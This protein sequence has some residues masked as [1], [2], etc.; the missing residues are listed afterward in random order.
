MNVSIS[1]IN[2]T[3]K[4]LTVEISPDEIKQEEQAL[5]SEFANQVKIPGFRPGKAPVNLVRQ[6]FG[7]EIRQEL[8]RKIMSEAYEYGVRESGFDVFAVVN[9]E[10]DDFASDSAGQLKLTVDIIPDFELPEYK[11]IRMNVAPT[12]V[13]DE[14]VDQAIDEMRAQR[15]EYNVVER[16]AEKGDYVRCSYKGSIEGKPIEEI[17]P[18]ARMYGTQ[19]S[20]WEEAGSEDAP[21]VRPVIDALVGMRKGDRNTVPWDIPEDFG[22]ESL[23]GKA[24]I[25]EVE[26]VEVRERVLPEIDET[27]LKSLQ[28]ESEEALRDRTRQSLE[29]RK[30]Q[31][32]T[33]SQRDQVN[34]K[35][36]ESVDFPLPES[37][38]EQQTQEILRDFMQRQMGQGVP[39]EE[40][41]KR[42]DELMEGA[43]RAA[44]DRVR[45]RI[46]LSKIAEKEKISV[47][48]ED[49]SSA[50]MRE[51]MMTRTQPDQLVKEIQKDRARLENMRESILVSKTLDFLLEQGAVNP[52]EPAG[53]EPVESETEDGRNADARES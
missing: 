10:N 53:V 39:Q 13:T 44:T 41:E 47:E 38:V 16:A 34:R 42:K 27:F 48:N 31:M 8:N 17:E 29:Q 1:D 49:F 15:A 7:K 30:E 21:G 45:L 22:V 26:V 37:A 2:P 43:G 52:V 33:S 5:L 28:V 11:G 20:T 12:A 46:V 32:N 51:A 35:L 3:R 24:A 19:N 6:R 18:E 9:I 25:Y 23:R 40:F 14:E 36:L 4:E 50:I